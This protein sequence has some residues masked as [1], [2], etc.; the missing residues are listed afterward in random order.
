MCFAIFLPITYPARE[1]NKIHKTTVTQVIRRLF[2]N[3]CQK[4]VILIASTKL[5]RFQLD[6]SDNAPEISFVI[7]DGF[8]NAMITVIYNGNNT[9]RVPS[10]RSAFII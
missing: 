4:S 3:V 8:L 1:C 6:G 5:S 7:S 2:P 10:T 9:V